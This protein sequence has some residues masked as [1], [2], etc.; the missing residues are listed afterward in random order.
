MNSLK[1]I[2][3]SAAL[4]MP[5]AVPASFGAS[6]CPECWE[7]AKADPATPCAVC[8]RVPVGVEAVTLDWYW[9]TAREAWRRAECPQA[10]QRK[11]CQRRSADALVVFD[12]E[13]EIF[14]SWYCPECRR[15]QPSNYERDADACVVCG[16]RYA[17]AETVFRRWYWC[18]AGE[19]WLAAPCPSHPGRRCCSERG[20][21]LL[22]FLARSEPKWA[23]R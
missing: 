5:A 10:A 16:R 14:P 6:F 13:D 20:G 4:S 15:F 9:C 3:M 22:A 23:G 1:I 17:V 18:K 7:F 11:C 19:E 8:G 12:R 21:M 2:L